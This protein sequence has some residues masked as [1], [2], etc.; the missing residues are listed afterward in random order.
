MKLKNMKK[1]LATVLSTTMVMGMSMTALAGEITSTS[2]TGGGTITAPIFSYD[3]THVVVPTSYGVA[4]NPDGLN[5]TVSTAT[6]PTVTTTSTVASK[7]YGII[8][9]S[10]KDK[11]VKVGLSV[12]ST[13]ARES[14]SFVDTAAEATGAE[15]GEYKIYLEVVP[16]D[17]TDIQIY[18]ASKSAEAPTTSTQPS[19]LAHV[20][21][22][23][24][25]STVPM[26][27]GDNEVAFKLGK[28][29]YSLKADGSLNLEGGISN[30]VH[31][32]YDVT[33]LDTDKGVTGFTFDG[34]MNSKADW[35]KV[36]GRIEITPTYTIETTDDSV[37][38]FAGTGAMAKLG[39]Q[40]TVSATG[41]I[42]ITG[43]T[44]DKKFQSMTITNRSAADLDIGLA[45]VTWNRDN[46]NDTTGGTITCQLGADWLASLRGVSTGEIK[47]TFS[48]NT[49]ITV[50]TNIPA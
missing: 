1:V 10:S 18:N 27:L 3:I 25:T 35:T 39:P 48:D 7:N 24:A 20:Q 36:T 33:A 30:D 49:F 26:K 11:L 19:S 6:N 34:A 47:V 21:M 5:V 15:K 16:A 14:V 29:A 17:G 37:T 31:D 41:L 4:F 8:N 50:K 38:V 22:T 44:A 12:T 40:V 43:M 42:T 28:A 13:E 23:K 46:Y 32:L 9:K 45:S 2:P